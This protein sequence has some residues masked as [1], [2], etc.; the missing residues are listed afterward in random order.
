MADQAH[1]CRKDDL[2]FCYLNADGE[3]YTY[4][5]TACGGCGHQGMYYRFTD[6]ATE[7]AGCE[8]VCPVCDHS[9]ILRVHAINAPK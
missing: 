5:Q 2:G 4:G 7:S 1:E 6:H 9:D 3:P 8:F